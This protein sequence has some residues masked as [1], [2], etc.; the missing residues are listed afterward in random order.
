MRK[1]L[2]VCDSCGKEESISGLSTPI[3]WLRIQGYTF[4]DPARIDLCPD[5]AQYAPKYVKKVLIAQAIRE[6]TSP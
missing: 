2:K 6:G 4:D 1:S 3:G 5:C